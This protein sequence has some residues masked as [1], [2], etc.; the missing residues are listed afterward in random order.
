MLVWEKN[1]AVMVFFISTVGCSYQYVDSYG[2]HHTWGLVH[3]TYREIPDDQADVIAHQVSTLGLAI[4]RLSRETGF[5]VGYTRNFEIQIADNTAG[6]IAINLDY[7]TR[8]TYKNVC[9][10]IEEANYA[11][12]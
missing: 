4:T 12:R 9:T 1:L 6:E 11:K 10:I 8:S 3:S 5:S 2:T 7:P